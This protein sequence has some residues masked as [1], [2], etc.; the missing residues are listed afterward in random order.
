MNSLIKFFQY[1]NED[2]HFLES[3]QHFIFY[4]L[5]NLIFYAII[6]NIHGYIG[7]NSIVFLFYMLFN[8]LI[9][10]MAA[11]MNVFKMWLPYVVYNL[12]YVFLV[13]LGLL[14]LDYTYFVSLNLFIHLMYKSHHYILLDKENRKND[15]WYH[16]IDFYFDRDDFFKKNNMIDFSENKSLEDEIYFLSEFNQSLKYPYRI[17]EDYLEKLKQVKLELAHHPFLLLS[18]Y[19]MILSYCHDEMTHGE[20]IKIKLSLYHE[21]VSAMYK[22]GLYSVDFKVD[23]SILRKIKNDDGK[24]TSLKNGV[25]RFYAMCKSNN[26]DIKIRQNLVGSTHTIRLNVFLKKCREELGN[27]NQLENALSKV[28]KKDHV[29][30]TRKYKQEKKHNN[31]DE[32]DMSGV[33][34]SIYSE[35][36]YNIDNSHD[37]DFIK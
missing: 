3:K 12:S 31:D 30:E 37:I 4:C 26:M 15:L 18:M 5:S 9:V 7:K 2:N 19:K 17:S 25:E 10:M 11:Q 24:N 14:K 22:N 27:G 20:P 36:D 1:N 34:V 33:G 32:I 35:S 6:I 29:S 21:D 23:T 13:Y 28:S 8:I 16:L